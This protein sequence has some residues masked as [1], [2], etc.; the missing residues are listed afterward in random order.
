ML[1]SAGASLAETDYQVRTNITENWAETLL[2]ISSD[3]FRNAIKFAFC[4]TG[5]L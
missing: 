4:L 1:V 2:M 3:Y 5:I